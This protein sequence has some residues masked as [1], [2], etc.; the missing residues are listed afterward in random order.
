[1]ALGVKTPGPPRRYWATGAVFSPGAH[2]AYR[3]KLWR[4]W[5]NTAPVVAFVSL[6]PST[7]DEYEDDPTIRRDIGFAQAWRFGG[8]VK[9]NLFGY[10]S[11]DPGGLLSV[12]DPVG[13]DN[14]AAIVEVVRDVARVVLAWGSHSSPA[15]LGALVAHRAAA[16][17]ERVMTHARGEVGD[18]GVNADGQPRHPLYLPKATGFRALSPTPGRG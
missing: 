12:D 2:P 14:D 17:R 3:Y 9:L 5:D 10:R 1:M 4:T 7:A 15:S 13:P 16:V 6:N 8:L 11:T 18:L